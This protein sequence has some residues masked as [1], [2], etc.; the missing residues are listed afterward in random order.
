M[1]KIHYNCVLY[2]FVKERTEAI[3]GVL[4]NGPN[5]NILTEKDKLS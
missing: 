4:Q 3:I 2:F 5:L 1:K